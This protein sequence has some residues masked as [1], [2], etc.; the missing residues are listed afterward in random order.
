MKIMFEFVALNKITWEEGEH[1]SEEGHRECNRETLKEKLTSYTMQSNISNFVVNNSENASEKVQSFDTAL[2]IFH[3]IFILFN[4]C[5][6]ERYFMC[7]ILL[8]MLL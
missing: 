2:V 6:F 5:P 3:C 4:L 7:I 1:G 8:F